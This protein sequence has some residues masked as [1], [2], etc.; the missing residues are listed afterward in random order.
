MR[1]KIEVMRIK[2]Y[3]WI[4]RNLLSNLVK[5]SFVMEYKKEKGFLGSLSGVMN[6]NS[7]FIGRGI[8]SS[9]FTKAR[10]AD[11]VSIST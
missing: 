6:E 5:Y 3:Q 10:L 7:F 4:F 9:L 1:F 11:S 8:G 2:L